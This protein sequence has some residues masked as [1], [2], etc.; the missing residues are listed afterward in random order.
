MKIKSKQKKK[1]E[2]QDLDAFCT[3][4]PDNSQKPVNHTTS[5]RICFV[6]K[7]RKY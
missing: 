6:L 1:T 2:K 3:G 7:V 5:F 4:P